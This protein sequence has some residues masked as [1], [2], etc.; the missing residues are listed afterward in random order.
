MTTKFRRTHGNVFA[1]LGFSAAEAENLKVRADLMHRLRKVIE[2]KS[3]HAG[4]G[5][6]AFQSKSTACQ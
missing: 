5:S 4:A 1:D 6:P 3:P 2:S